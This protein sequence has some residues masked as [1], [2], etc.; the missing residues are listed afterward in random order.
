MPIFQAER[1]V[2]FEVAAP[3]PVDAVLKSHLPGRQL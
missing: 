2:A 1:V 3:H